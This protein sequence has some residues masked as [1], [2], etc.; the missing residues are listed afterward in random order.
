MLTIDAIGPAQRAAL[1]AILHSHDGRIH[2]AAGGWWV[3]TD[4]KGRAQSFTTRTVR[5]MGN[6]W[7]VDLTD[8]F[9]P[10]A[11]LTTQGRALAQQLHDQQAAA[12]A[13]A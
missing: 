3:A 13:R 4:A 8:R 7:L 1:L 2:R 11:P 5:A 12:E 9:A 6:A 10:S